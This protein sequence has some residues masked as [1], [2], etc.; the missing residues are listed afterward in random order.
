MKL[1]VLSERTPPSLQYSIRK[2]YKVSDIEL[3]KL[4]EGLRLYWYKDSLGK[5]TGGYGHLRLK[6]DPDHFDQDQANTWL[7]SDITTSRRAADKQ[8]DQLPIQTQ[9]LYDVLVSVNFQLGGSWYK[10]HKKTWALMVQGRYEEAA[11]E[12]WNS[13]WRRQTPVRVKDLQTVL[14][15]AGKLARQYEQSL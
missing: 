8:F 13:D 3:V 5:P 14:V 15:A 6:G 10:E 9:A 12:A 2:P 11:A 1:S 7:L 4:R